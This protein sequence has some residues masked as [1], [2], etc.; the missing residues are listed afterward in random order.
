MRGT[1]QRVAFAIVLERPRIIARVLERPR[2]P[3]AIPAPILG[4]VRLIVWNKAV[5]RAVPSAARLSFWRLSLIVSDGFWFDTR[6]FCGVYD[7][8]LRK[9]EEGLIDLVGPARVP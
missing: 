9:V 6:K 7:R 4:L 8:P 2:A 1:G 3:V 5:A